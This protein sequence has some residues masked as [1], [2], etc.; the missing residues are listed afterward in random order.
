MPL[1]N[2]VVI[3]T[4]GAC[5]P[6]PGWG[7]W[8]AILLYA[9][10]GDIHEREITGGIADTTNNRMEIMAVLQSLQALKRPC[11]VTIYSDS[12]YVVN[13]VGK[14]LDGMPSKAGWMVGWK[15]DEWT[16]KGKPLMNVDLWQLLDTELRRHR[17]VNLKWIRGHAEH[18]YNDRCDALAGQAR[19]KIADEARGNGLSSN[20]A[21][22]NCWDAGS[23]DGRQSESPQQTRPRS[24]NRSARPKNRRNS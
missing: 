9:K 3:Y 12:E 19:K 13:A 18:E 6:N 10:D 21:S 5:E 14:W 1:E 11:S 15:R 17:S 7:G 24:R 8:A 4:D 16:R 20:G 2:E 23:N 22:D